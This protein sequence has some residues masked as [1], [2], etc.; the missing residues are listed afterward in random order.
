M[1][2]RSHKRFPFDNA[3]YFVIGVFIVSVFGFVPSYFPG[4]SPREVEFTF[5]THFHAVNMVLWLCVLTAQPFL[6][7]HRLNRWH[8]M[9]GKVSYVQVPLLL[10]STLL[11][12]HDRISTSESPT[13]YQFWVPFKDLVTIGTTYGLAIYYRRNAAYHA[14]FMVGT[15]FMLVEPGLA[16]A[17]LNFIP[18]LSPLHSTYLLIDSTLLYLV[19]KDR[20]LSKGTWIFRLVFGMTLSVHMIALYLR[21]NPELPWFTNFVH[22]FSK[23]PLT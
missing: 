1:S 5:Y 20:K 7:R 3:G 13:P 10:L 23:L 17:I 11:L 2:I 19:V 16:R 22:W 18:F 15:C 21:G 4:Y 6:I 14:R 12:I 8:R 9:L